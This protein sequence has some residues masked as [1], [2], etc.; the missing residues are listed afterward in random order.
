MK[1]LMFLAIGDG[2]SQT[3]DVCTTVDRS[4]LEVFEIYVS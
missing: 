3:S 4:F 1:H 2:V